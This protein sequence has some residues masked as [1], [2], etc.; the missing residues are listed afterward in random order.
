MFGEGMGGVLRAFGGRM[1]GEVRVFE[2]LVNWDGGLG[3]WWGGG[4][5]PCMFFL[6]TL[7]D[8]SLRGI[9]AAKIDV[10]K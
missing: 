10:R 1:G 3:A 8:F 6:A 5:P 2:G 7:G 4:P 9:S